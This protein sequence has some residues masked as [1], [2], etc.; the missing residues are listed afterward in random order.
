M[1]T[2]VNRYHD[3]WYEDA[4]KLADSVGVTP[5]MPR[6]CNTQIHR[7]NIPSNTISEYYRRTITIPILNEVITDLCHRFNPANMIF[8]GAVL[9]YPITYN[10]KNAQDRKKK[11]KDFM[12]YYSTDMANTES[13]DAEIDCWETFWFSS[14]KGS[15]LPDTVKTSMQHTMTTMYPN[16]FIGLSLLG[17]IPVTT[18]S[19]DHVFL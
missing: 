8:V 11:V 3:Q 15:V 19:C 6:V 10:K 9:L 14:F 18:C 2:S 7:E 16:I 4:V 1:C 13:C 12:I 5:K 17:V